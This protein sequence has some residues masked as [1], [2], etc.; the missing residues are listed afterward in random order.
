MVALV[1]PNGVV[2]RVPEGSEATYI[3]SGFRRTEADLG[4]MAYEDL[5]ALAK[6]RGLELK[7]KRPRKAA[8][9][10]MLGG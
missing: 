2:V 9:I 7:P 4:A 3:S 6:E 5:I 1:A 8:L 10:A